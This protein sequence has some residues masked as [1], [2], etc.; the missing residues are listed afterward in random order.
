M[1]FK[2]T[3]LSVFIFLCLTTNGLSQEQ[4][5]NTI[6]AI[7]DNDGTGDTV[8]I[9][10]DGNRIIIGIDQQEVNT[11][12]T[13]G[14]AK[15]YEINANVFQQLGQ[16]LE[17]EMIDQQFGHSVEISS[18][19]NRI[20]VGG[21]IGA[22]IY[23]LVANTWQQVGSLITVPNLPSNGRID[24]IEFSQDGNTVAISGSITDTK[25]GVFEFLGN[26]WVQKG[27]FF[28]G[29]SRTNFG[30]T[31]SGNR[32]AIEQL[33]GAGLGS[34]LAFDFVN[35]NWQQIG[36]ALEPPT[37]YR[38]T[39]GI[40]ISGNGARIVFG[41][42]NTDNSGNGAIAIFDFS[43]G[44]WFLQND[45]IF[46]SF[47]S[48]FGQS[49]RLN[50]DGNRFIFGTAEDGNIQ[51]LSYAVLYSFENNQ[52]MQKGN[53]LINQSGDETANGQVDITFDG[54]NIVMGGNRIETDDP[55]GFVKSFNY[56]GLLSTNEFQRTEVITVYPNPTSDILNINY[57]FT[58]E[59]NYKIFNLNGGEFLNGKAENK[60]IDLKNLS[61]GIYFLTLVFKNHQ[62]TVKIIK[63]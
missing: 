23:D 11:L 27:D 16:T 49:L 51:E 40:D 41:L 38:V 25:V 7:A 58:N 57:N 24:M 13:A 53:Q 39:E 12:T 17:G 34:V 14:V 15:I 20:A 30:L 52:W 59:L 43:N 60:Q 44:D 9:S 26:D 62:E 28:S 45:L 33:N 8:A 19:G 55:R 4:V 21:R 35:G 22:K 32:I 10:D 47:E 1:K 50:G 54:N 42:D 61:T 36:G 31:M 2:L 18:S 6:I 63:K 37:G 48:R 56:S 29:N 3:L 46:T 5:G